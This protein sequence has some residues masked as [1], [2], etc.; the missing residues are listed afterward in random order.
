M[1]KR[2]PLLPIFWKQLKQV[3]LPTAIVF[4]VVALLGV[5]FESCRVGQQAGELGQEVTVL[6]K[7][8]QTLQYKLTEVTSDAYAEKVARE[9]FK[10]SRPEE[11]VFIPVPQT[12]TPPT[13]RPTTPTPTPLPSSGPTDRSASHWK[14]W[15]DLFFGP[16]A[17]AD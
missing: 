11:K 10:W 15:I 8:K 5:T 3:L 17:P 12:G 16:R 13:Q 2:T 4:Y 14:E 7:E 9:E 6:E 1:A